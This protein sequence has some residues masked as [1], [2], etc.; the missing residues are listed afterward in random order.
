MRLQGQWP[1]PE[2][3]EAPGGGGGGGR[4]NPL[5]GVNGVGFGENKPCKVPVLWGS[6]EK[7]GLEGSKVSLCQTSTVLGGKNAIF[8]VAFPRNGGACPTA[9]SRILDGVKLPLLQS[10]MGKS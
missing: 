7:T 10:L 1:L 6:E 2:V 5:Q 4:N 8:E 3:L 9:A